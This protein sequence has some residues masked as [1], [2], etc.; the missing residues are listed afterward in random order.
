MTH[1]LSLHVHSSAPVE[2]GEFYQT[3]VERSSCWRAHSGRLARSLWRRRSLWRVR[4][5]LSNSL[6]AE[7]IPTR[8]RTVSIVR[9]LHGQTWKQRAHFGS[10]ALF[11]CGFA[12]K[13]AAKQG[14]LRLSGLQAAT[15]SSGRSTP[16]QPRA[17]ALIDR[18]ASAKLAL[19]LAAVRSL[20]RRRAHFGGAVERRTQ[21]G[22]DE[23]SLQQMTACA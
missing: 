17:E 15:H 16:S 9:N 8:S 14:N 12:P 10:H 6:R 3:N 18:A 22:S 13:R 23:K 2:L 20:W 5:R 4:M 19:T 21:A 1:L 7:Q 11:P